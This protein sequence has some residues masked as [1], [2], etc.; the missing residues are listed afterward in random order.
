MQKLAEMQQSGELKSLDQRLSDL[1]NRLKSAQSNA[2]SAKSAEQAD[3]ISKP[4]PPV[5]RKSDT[6]AWNQMTKD[7][8]EQELARRKS[9]GQ[10]L[11][12][13]YTVMLYEW[14]KISDEY[15]EITEPAR[16]ELANI[17]QELEPYKT[18]NVDVKLPFFK[19]DELATEADFVQ[20]T[21]S[22]QLNII[23]AKLRNL[24]SMLLPAS[25]KPSVVRALEERVHSLQQSAADNFTTVQYTGQSA[26]SRITSATMRTETIYLLNTI[27]QELAWI[28]QAKEVALPAVLLKTTTIAQRRIADLEEQLK[29][30]MDE[31]NS[32]RRKVDSLNSGTKAVVTRYDRLLIGSGYAAPAEPD[33]A[34]EPF[35]PSTQ[36]APTLFDRKLAVLANDGNWSG[37][38]AALTAFE[39]M[40]Q[41][42]QTLSRQ[43]QDSTNH[44]TTFVVKSPIDMTVSEKQS[45]A[46][47][48]LVF[49]AAANLETSITKA[50]MM[51]QELEAY[52]L[53]K[54]SAT[55]I[56]L[57]PIEYDYKGSSAYRFYLLEQRFE[58]NQKQ[59]LSLPLKDFSLQLFDMKGR[60]EANGF[61]AS[62]L[63]GAVDRLL[64]K[65]DALDARYRSAQKP[66]PELQPKIESVDPGKEGTSSPIPRTA[67]PQP[68]PVGPSQS[69]PANY[70]QL[71][72]AALVDLATAYQQE[73]LRGFMQLVSPDFLGDDFLLDRALRRDY[74]AFDNINLRLSVN[75]INVDTRGRAK[76][77]VNYNRSVTA[78]QDGKVYSDR[79]I[80]LFTFHLQGGKVKLY[81]MKYP[82]L[83]GLSEA[84][85]LATGDVKSSENAMVLSIDRKGQVSVLPYNEARN[86]AEQSGVKRGNNV[87]LRAIGFYGPY[88]CW[89]FEDNRRTQSADL[90]HFDGD[91]LF[92]GAGIALRSGTLYKELSAIDISAVTEAPDPSVTTYSSGW[93]HIG[94]ILNKVVALKLSNG[95]FAL[96]QVVSHPNF[97]EM[98]F[99]YKYQPSGSRSF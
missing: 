90:H 99:D 81:D 77:L 53:L 74:R 85:Q 30:Q 95:H 58:T 89:S 93:L 60:I 21:M 63:G 62:G 45:L 76:V 32:I 28:N 4:L 38:T 26:V 17:L 33:P 41:K 68:V 94:D 7:E 43:Y 34:R 6:T 78:Q 46:N 3:A 20:T 86:V 16:G 27:D 96:I 25:E 92:E 51:R 35:S 11:S 52:K 66:S 56:G 72:R 79:G 8:R 88:E 69:L 36:F 22:A 84:S 65:I 55:L 37:V 49:P 9:L 83:F 40:Q 57:P 31:M 97:T 13:Q 75:S 87:R 64:G 42:A 47:I 23:N 15:K 14:A 12:Q 48:K 71:V 39:Q 50:E 80:T 5:A 54:Q 70:E 2:L 73:N 29:N 61:A 44:T 10:S 19:L 82:I 91:I 1:Q 98:Y 59:W 67:A 18:R 24:Q